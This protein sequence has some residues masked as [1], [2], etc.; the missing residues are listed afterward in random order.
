MLAL[1]VRGERLRAHAGQGAVDLAAALGVVALADQLEVDG[2]VAA[3]G[4]AGPLG[5][6]QPA[7]GE[8][9]GELGPVVGDEQRGQQPRRRRDR[10]LLV[11]LVRGEESPAVLGDQVLDGLDGPRLD[12][13]QRRAL[14]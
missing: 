14:G 12:D 6:E 9:Q 11:D 13:D 2:Q 1:G 3:L 8:H 7:S 5:D 4:P 10:R